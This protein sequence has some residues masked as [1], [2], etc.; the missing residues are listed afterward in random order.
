MS[1]NESTGGI[2][3]MKVLCVIDNLSTGGAQRQIINLA[4]GLKRRGHGVSVFCYA[5]GDLLAER[6]A[7]EA[8]PVRIHLKRSR[9]SLDVI[10]DLRHHLDEGKY[11]AVVSFLTTPN[12]YAILSSRLSQARPPVVVSERFCDLPG[13]ASPAE[14]GTRQLYRLSRAIV[15]NSHHQ[16]ENFLRR[17]PWM[18][19]RLMTVYNGYDLDLFV[20]P[21][22]EPVNSQPRV[23]VIASV[24]R[25]KNGLCLVR[26]LDILKRQSDLRIHV[27]WVGQRVMMGDRRVYFEAMAAEIERSGLAD[28][29]QWLDQRTDIIA[30]LHQHDVLVHPS[31]GEGLPNVVCEAMA[32][33][34]PVIVSNALDHPRLVED[35]KSGFLFDWREPEDLARKLKAFYDLSTDERH[36]LGQRGRALAEKNLSLERYVTEYEDILSRVVK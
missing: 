33:G 17:Y 19:G 35:G 31:Y 10:G 34:R 18:K 3:P 30:L 21:A 32:C 6:L 24:S 5:P 20:P 36:R 22:A 12:F 16:R 27:S 23:L 29:W 25:Y 11:Q 9:F 26:A 4:V 8:I 1:H 28:Q 13:T 14:L 2:A 15:V 7:K